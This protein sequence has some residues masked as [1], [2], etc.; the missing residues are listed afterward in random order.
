MLLK[1]VGVVA[2]NMDIKARKMKS[3][4]SSIE[5][6]KLVGKLN[7]L[8]KGEYEQILIALGPPAGVIP[9]ESA[10]QG[11]RTFALFQWLEGSTGP[12][13]SALIE[14]LQQIP[15]FD[16]NEIIEA[17][18]PRYQVVLDMDA[19]TI[20]M[21]DLERVV[22]GI[23]I[24]LGDETIKLLDVKVG[25]LKIDVTGDSGKL[26][27]LKD[28]F[29]SKRITNIDGIYITEVDKVGD[30]A[31]AIKL[32]V[33][34]WNQWRK[35]Y[36]D[37]QIDLYNAD[38][39]D[40]VLNGV[41]LNKALLKG[42]NLGNTYLCGADL[43]EANL[44]GAYLNGAHLSGADFSR[45]DLSEAS[46]R[47]SCLRGASLNRAIL[48]HVDLSFSNLRGADL[49]R[50]DLQEAILRGANLRGVDLDNADL[51]GA[52]LRGA[53]LDEA[54]LR[55]ANLDNS[56]LYDA[57]LERT[58]LSN[59]SFKDADVRGSKF[60][61]NKG[62]PALETINLRERGANILETVVSQDILAELLRN[63]R[64]VKQD[65]KNIGKF[66]GVLAFLVSTLLLL[67]IL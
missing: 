14:L 42:A 56:T 22:N 32:G 3:Q 50:A 23:G 49:S 21:N 28:L 59:A 48:Q 29:E 39:Q 2:S 20:E 46:F 60:R 1:A 44:V 53:D 26:K 17:T 8:P 5:R 37:I 40:A 45:A 35:Y 65:T 57:S 12:G 15:N 41:S 62:L 51:R 10:A 33:Q 6:F 61:G 16:I 13:L 25:S 52:N 18:T 36:P 27:Y 54:S 63:S 31:T 38:L 55:G 24:L 64:E 47:D 11:G 4:L 9:A 30:H 7:S 43:S 19:T 58:D 67:M 66:D 34:S